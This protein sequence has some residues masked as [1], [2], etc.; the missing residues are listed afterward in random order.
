[1]L[2]TWTVEDDDCSSITSLT[3]TVRAW[4][5]SASKLPSLSR[6]H[7]VA[8][9]TISHDMQHVSDV[10]VVVMAQLCTCLGCRHAARQ[11]FFDICPFVKIAA[12]R[13][14]HS[15]TMESELANAMSNEVRVGIIIFSLCELNTY[16]LY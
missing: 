2:T 13:G 4:P 15:P 16:N 6:I 9:A 7:S 11:H 3:A 12:R 10:L 8:H 1:M 5:P 14:R